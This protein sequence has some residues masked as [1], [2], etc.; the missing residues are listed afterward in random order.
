MFAQASNAFCRDEQEVRA[1]KL[2][3][4]LYTFDPQQGSFRPV[5]RMPAHL[6]Q[7]LVQALH[8]LHQIDTAGQA[9]HEAG[10]LLLCLPVLSTAL[11]I[12]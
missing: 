8:V 11:Y 1:F 6:P 9:F 7:Q 4:R 12:M 5:P 3:L 10:Q 2:F